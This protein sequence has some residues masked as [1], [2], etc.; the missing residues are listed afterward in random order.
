[1]KKLTAILL[2]LAFALSLT[3]C[4]EDGYYV[5][6]T[7]SARYVE[8]QDELLA[9]LREL[10]AGEAL[11]GNLTA[12]ELERLIA[13]DKLWLTRQCFRLDGERGETVSAQ[14]YGAL[15]EGTPRAELTQVTARR[16]VDF[17]FLAFVLLPELPDGA[18]ER[19][20]RLQAS[21][22]FLYMDPLACRAGYTVT[23]ERDGGVS[24]RSMCA[25]PDALERGLG[26]S[27]FTLSFDLP[28]DGAAEDFYAVFSCENTLRSYSEAANFNVFLNFS[29]GGKT[30]ECAS[31]LQYAPEEAH[32]T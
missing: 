4:G 12:D 1:M 22:L 24:I 23:E 7:G 11:C 18:R 21:D 29:G 15:P 16:G 28:D 19:T 3:G 8:G 32:T 27:S 25:E 14:D 17:Y 2:A 31:L 9:R 20:F 13:A 10:G 5:P 30:L 26:A 6:D